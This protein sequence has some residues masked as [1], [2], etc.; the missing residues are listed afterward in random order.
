MHRSV[1]RL[2]V[3]ISPPADSSLINHESLQSDPPSSSFK[4][5][6]WRKL[7]KGYALRFVLSMRSLG[8]STDP[9]CGALLLVLILTAV[10]VMVVATRAG[11]GTVPIDRAQVRQDALS[12]SAVHK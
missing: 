2:S 6:T 3:T 7:V 10:G 9:L 4:R 5:V 1:S 12:I 11:S 8:S